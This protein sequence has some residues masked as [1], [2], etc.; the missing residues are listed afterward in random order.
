M[1]VPRTADDLAFLRSGAPPVLH[2]T[3]ADIRCCSTPSSRRRAR[4]CSDA[5]R[6]ARSRA[7]PRDTAPRAGKSARPALFRA[8]VAERR[9]RA[10]RLRSLG[11]A[12]LG[13][14]RRLRLT[15]VASRR[16]LET[17][18]RMTHT[19][20]PGPTARMKSKKEKPVRHGTRPRRGLVE[21]V[22][23]EDR[24]EDVEASSPEYSEKGASATARPRAPTSNGPSSAS[25]FSAS[26]PARSGAG[27]VG[28]GARVRTLRA[29]AK[30]AALPSR[31][32]SPARISPQ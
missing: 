18:T 24:E 6:I 32:T 5:R 2:V 12:V 19:E 7:R 3:A 13:P 26:K 14:R 22:P 9:A 27:R 20:R 31:S 15:P 10:R 21:A 8:A 17:G 30:A 1:R 23:V 25:S 16:A 28:A 4:S 29:G 11:R